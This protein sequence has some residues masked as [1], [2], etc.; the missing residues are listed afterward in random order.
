MRVSLDL[1]D[2]LLSA[3]EN[4]ARQL[5]AS[6]EAVAIKAIEDAVDRDLPGIEVQAASGRVQLPLVRSANP[7]SLRSMT[8]AE[9]DGI[10]GN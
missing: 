2:P 5:H 4:R 8:N 6:I 1:P 3:L 10:P 9:I 7:G